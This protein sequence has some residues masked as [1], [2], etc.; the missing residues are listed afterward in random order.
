MFANRSFKC[1][2]PEVKI[3]NQCHGLW[4]KFDLQSQSGTPATDL[5]K[6]E[7]T[8]GEYWTINKEFLYLVVILPIELPDGFCRLYIMRDITGRYRL[9]QERLNAE[10][11]AAVAQTSITYNHEINNP[12]FGIMG[13]LEIMLEDE[14]DPKKFEELELIYDAA[15][16]IADVTKRL[17]RITRP[18]IREYV[19]K[20][21]MLDLT[22]SSE[23]EF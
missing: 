5:S 13:Y 12:L 11:L 17:K 16:R 4:E 15:K 8:T 23:R 18:V 3:G 19:G 2:F 20:V 9:E 6:N 10:R 21:K 14:K 22:A 1:H 7:P